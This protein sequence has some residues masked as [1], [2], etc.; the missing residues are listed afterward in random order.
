MTTNRP[1]RPGPGPRPR[2]AALAIPVGIVML[3]FWT[4]SIL[5]VETPGW[6]HLLLTVGVTL[7]IYGVVRRGD[8]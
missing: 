1:E 7:V 2:M 4:I 8:P 5:T 6:M 3:V